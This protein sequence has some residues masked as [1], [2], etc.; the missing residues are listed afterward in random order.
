MSTKLVVPKRE[1]EDFCRRHAI[2]RLALFGSVLREDFGPE[3]DVDVLVEFKPGS[4]VGLEFFRMQEELS[5][6]LGRE[7]DLSTPG[8]IS[9]YFREQVLA[10]A[11]EVY[12]EAE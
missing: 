10:E 11:E 2:R 9:K 7:V 1:L 5:E 3:S 12:A 8:F 6:I 4:Q